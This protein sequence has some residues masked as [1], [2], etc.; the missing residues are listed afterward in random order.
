MLHAE[1][2]R[3]MVPMMEVLFVTAFIGELVVRFVSKRREFLYDFWNVLDFVREE[4]ITDG[5]GTPNP[6]PR[7]LVNWCF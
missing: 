5:I 1:N 3:E 7:N 6:N 2:K 4:Y